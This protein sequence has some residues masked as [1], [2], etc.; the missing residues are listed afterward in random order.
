[1]REFRTGIS[2]KG[3]GCPSQVNARQPMI[4]GG[5]C[6]SRPVQ[7]FQ[8]FQIPFTE[9]TI[10]EALES[11]TLHPAEL[12]GISDRK[13]TLSYGSDAD[14][15]L[16]DAELNAVR[17]Y[18]AGQCVWSSPTTGEAIREIRVS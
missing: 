4:P 5:S 18:I 2:L 12:L 14:F 8:C 11:A 3:T 15:V 1:M 17:T 7:L 6:G 13:G 10:V 9:C 16:L